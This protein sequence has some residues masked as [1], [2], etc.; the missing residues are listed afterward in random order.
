MRAY[1]LAFSV[2]ATCRCSMA[3]REGGLQYCSFP[4]DWTGGPTVCQK[5]ELLC[6]DFKG[7]MLRENFVK[8]CESRYGHGVYWRDD[9]LGYHFAHEFNDLAPIDEQLPAVRE[10][11]MRRGRRLRAMLAKA[12]RALVVFVETPDFGPET[13]ESLL[14]ARELLMVRWPNVMFDMLLVR[15]AEGVPLKKFQ[16]EESDGVRMVQFDFRDRRE[17]DGNWMA[18]QK[19][20]GKWLKAEYAVADYRTEEERR[21]WSEL[22]RAQKFARYAATGWLDYFVTKYRYKLYVHLRKKLD[23]RG[24][25]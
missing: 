1:D 10:R 6:R 4:F 18:D 19:L 3:L 24:I 17:K 22:R 21:K 15:H 5:V 20:I 25:I 12:K 14:K 23:P 2:G 7:W 9:A 8:V 11:L 16:D 13:P